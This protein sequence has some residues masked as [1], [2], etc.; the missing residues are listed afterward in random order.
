MVNRTCMRWSK[1]APD[2]VQMAAKWAQMGP[3]WAKIELRGGQG[4][5]I[6]HQNWPQIASPVRR[7]KMYGRLLNM[8]LRWSKV[9]QVRSRWR[10]DGPR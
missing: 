4:R 3:T 5:L 1:V 2:G 7:H 9:A 10:P 6:W 8:G